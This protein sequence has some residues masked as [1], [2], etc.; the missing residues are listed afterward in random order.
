MVMVFGEITS[1][2]TVD[3]EAII[4]KTVKEIGFISDDVG[5]D[6]DKC[7]V[8]SL[9]G[10]RQLRAPVAAVAAAPAAGGGQLGNGG[11]AP[12]LRCPAWPAR[13]SGRHAEPSG[14]PP[15]A[16]DAPDSEHRRS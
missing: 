1:K 10:R 11:Q 14:G 9:H 15:A 12:P 6:G 3:Y 13:L 7:K 16:A 4:R 5:L 8:G 2:A